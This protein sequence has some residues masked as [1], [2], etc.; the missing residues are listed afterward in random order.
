MSDSVTTYVFG[1]PVFVAWLDV[2]GFKSAMEHRTGHRSSGE[3]IFQLW[4]NAFLPLRDKLA[5]KPQ[6]EKSE[7]GNIN[8]VQLSDSLVLY[9]QSANRMLDLVCDVYGGALV[10]GVPI[11]G[12]LAYGE[13]F[14]VEDSARPGTAITLF[15][16][17][18]ID[19]YE[20]EQSAKGCGMR[21]FL[22]PSFVSQLGGSVPGARDHCW[23]GVGSARRACFAC[24]KEG[25]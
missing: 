12:G 13:L 17:G 6:D 16:A 8:F 7:G 3:L 10:W 21:L 19:A 18:Q 11:R 24:G 1:A 20:T 14:H 5:P 9:G 25:S 4:R 2:L 23:T 22:S 15:G